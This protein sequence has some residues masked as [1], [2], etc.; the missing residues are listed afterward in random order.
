MQSHFTEQDTER[1]YDTEEANYRLFWDKEGS[2][3]WGYFTD[4]TGGDFLAAS[5]YL[6]E[7]MLAK[8]GIDKSSLVLDIG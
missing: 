3:H 5:A 1:Y 6:N 7:L 2:V 4:A 8:S